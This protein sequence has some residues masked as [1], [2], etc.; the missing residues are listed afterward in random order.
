MKAT[1]ALANLPY[2]TR[3]PVERGQFGLF[4]RKQTKQGSSLALVSFTFQKL[5]EVLDIQVR[6]RAVH[7]LPLCKR[8]AMIN[9][10][11][12]FEHRKRQIYG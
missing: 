3:L 2:V 4:F 11:H 9:V 6:N 10:W 12:K 7:G 5:L 8:R 1:K